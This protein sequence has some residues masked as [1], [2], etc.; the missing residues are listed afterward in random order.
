MYRGLLEPR[1][2]SYWHRELG[3]TSWPLRERNLTY[4]GRLATFIGF[5]I[6]AFGAPPAPSIELDGRSITYHEL[7]EGL[8]QQAA[9][10]PSGGVTCYSHQAMTMCNA[11]LLINNVLHDRLYGTEYR[12]TNNLWLRTLETHLTRPEKEGPLFF[13][14]TQSNSCCADDGLSLGTDAWTLF[15]M[16]SVVPDRVAKWF[17]DWRKNIKVNEDRAY[18]EIPQKHRD[19]EFSSTELA[20]AWTYC[21]AKELGHSQLAWQMSWRRVHLMRWWR[22]AILLRGS[23]CH[24]QDAA[25]DKCSCFKQQES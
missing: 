2:W 9:N 21:L 1:T 6:D 24:E 17:P 15:L 5:Y 7:S 19:I 20:S 22:Q 10:S 13:F 14:G 11:H 8:V 23:K 16:S 12:S 25:R 18:V 3:E 4:A